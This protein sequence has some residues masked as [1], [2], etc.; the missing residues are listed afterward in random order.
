MLG[1]T[2]SQWTLETKETNSPTGGQNSVDI[3]DNCVLE[4]KFQEEIGEPDKSQKD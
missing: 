1:I 2:P 3:Q 4:L